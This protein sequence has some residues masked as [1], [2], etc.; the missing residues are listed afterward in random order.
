[1]GNPQ[2]DSQMSIHSAKPLVRAVFLPIA[3]ITVSILVICG[4]VAS[5]AINS[6]VS[7]AFDRQLNAT[8]AL[9]VENIRTDLL[10]GAN[11]EVY[12]KCKKL[13]NDSTI[14]GVRIILVGGD[15]VCDLPPDGSVKARS[16]EVSSSL[17]FDLQEKSKAAMVSISYSNSLK[18]VLLIQSVVIVSGTI[19]VL[20]VALFVFSLSI[21]RKLTDPISALGNQ[22]LKGD[23]NA[24]AKTANG[25]LQTP[26]IELNLLSHGIQQLTARLHQSQAELVVKTRESAVARMTQMLAHDVRKPFSILRMGLTLLGRAQDPAAVKATLARLMPEIDK[27]VISVDGLISD[28]MEVGS[29]ST[30]LIQEP[31]SPESL[32]EASLGE[33]F[34]VYPKA[35]VSITYDLR[36]THMVNVHVQKV[37]RVFSNIFGNSLQAMKHKGRI[38]VKTRE[39]NGFIEFCLGNAGS[40]IPPESLP[41][42]FEAFFTSG[43]KGGSGL[44]LAIAEKVVKAHGGKIWCESS[45]TG[46]CPEGKVEFFFTLP[47]AQASVAKRT[48]SLPAHSS[49]ITKTL[50]V[51]STAGA[52]QTG[53]IDKGELTLE[54]DLAEKSQALAR[55]IRVLIV[56]DEAVYRSAL[57]AMLSRSSELTTSLQIVTSIDAHTALGAVA[58]GPAFDLI[59]TDVDMGSN[60]PSGFELVGELRTI[61]VDSLICVH[62]NRMVGDDHRTAIEAGANAFLPK[63]IAR[64][65]LLK[66]VLQS[67]AKAEEKAPPASKPKFIVVD[68]SPLVL[69]AWESCLKDDATLYLFTSF[70][71]LKTHL[72]QN[73]GIIQQLTCAVTDMHLEDASA[74]GAD[75]GR[76]LKSVRPDLK[77]FLSSDGEFPPEELRGAIDHQISKGPSSVAELTRLC[78]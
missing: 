70:A 24:I 41:K 13:L 17:Y 62:S 5:V 26:I 12:R 21:S 58:A 52:A 10:S 39:Q 31:G 78:Q 59:V 25:L 1:M 9:F 77:V 72:E 2:D 35:D 54:A 40:V 68:D 75:V 61:G 6:A 42:L 47:V 74:D 46:D 15:K 73:P 53:S 28:V 8:Q 29:T 43:K 20:M 56:D 48:T 50:L 55:P 38:W 34:R 33:I 4:I 67:A 51:P 27:A 16:V 60:S 64:G 7:Q 11:S 57:E 14:L 18:D 65:Q 69:D 3:L 32:I 23:I 66:L 19:L 44:G 22:F 45:K 63:P 36:H 71:E 76:Y 30:Q 37:A 49:E